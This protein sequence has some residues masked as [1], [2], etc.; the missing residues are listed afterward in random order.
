M[1]PLTPAMARLAGRGARR[2]P[3]AREGREFVDGKVLGFLKYGDHFRA[4]G[5][6][7]SQG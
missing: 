4:K 2:P 3:Q 5:I 1:V 6:H 7:P